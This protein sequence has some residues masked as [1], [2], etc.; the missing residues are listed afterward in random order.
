MLNR[1]EFLSITDLGGA[2]LLFSYSLPLKA[3]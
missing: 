2:A 3:T 1:R